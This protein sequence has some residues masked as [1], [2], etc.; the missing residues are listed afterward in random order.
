M[1]KSPRWDGKLAVA[2]AVRTL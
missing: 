1:K 2:S